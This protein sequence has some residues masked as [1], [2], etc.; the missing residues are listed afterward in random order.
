MGN[1]IILGWGF[2]DVP[3]KPDRRK[4]LLKK[5]LNQLH[6]GDFI[7]KSCQGSEKNAK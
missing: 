7:Y 6:V 5:N 4:H 1:I 2:I 3:L